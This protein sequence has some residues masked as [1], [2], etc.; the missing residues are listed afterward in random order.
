MAYRLFGSTQTD[1]IR[2][3]YTAPKTGFL[4]QA[5]N[6]TMRKGGRMAGDL[7]GSGQVKIQDCDNQLSFQAAAQIFIHTGMR[8][9]IV[10]IACPHGQRC[11]VAGIVL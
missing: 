1:R 6:P 7:P 2:L 4:C 5:A 8:V 3:P 10:V 9:A 11:Y